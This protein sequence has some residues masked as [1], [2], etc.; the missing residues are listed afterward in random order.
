MKF[1]NLSRGRSEYLS[2]VP[3]RTS[4]S[5]AHV[6]HLRPGY[7]KESVDYESLT[8]AHA[9]CF[10]MVLSLALSEFGI[11]PTD[12]RTTA[13]L[14][15]LAIDGAIGIVRIDLSTAVKARGLTAYVCQQAAEMARVICVASHAFVAT[16]QIVVVASVLS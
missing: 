14:E 10:S 12:V 16:A 3:P 11:I 8:Q 5:Q 1:P 2:T 4:S 9:A 6:R 13:K 7:S 15:K